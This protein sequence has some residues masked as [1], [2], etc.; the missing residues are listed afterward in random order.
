M[1]TRRIIAAIQ[2]LIRWS[3]ANNVGNTPVCYVC[4]VYICIMYG[5]C[6]LHIHMKIIF[7][8]IFATVIT[9]SLNSFNLIILKAMNTDQ[10]LCG[11]EVEVKR[12]M[13]QIFSKKLEKCY[14]EFI[15]EFMFLFS[16]F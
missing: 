12:K 2:I 16:E 14:K 3:S 9:F 5:L 10:L 7:C 13:L 1:L 6:T 8:Y 4:Y 11:Y 15:Q